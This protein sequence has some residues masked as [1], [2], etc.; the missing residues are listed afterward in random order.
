[1]TTPTVGLDV[2]DPVLPPGLAAPGADRLAALEA[3]LDSLT[4][5]MQHLDQQVA[6]LTGKAADD[7]RRQ[8]EWDDLAADFTPVAREMY[9][10][11]VAQLEEIQSY[12]QLEDVLHLV[13]RLAR[14]TRNLNEMLDLAESI[15]DL[16]RDLGPLTKEIFAQAVTT[17]DDLERKGY[18]GFLRQ[19]QY[20]LD[21]V[22][23]SFGEDDVRLL[24]DNIVVILN[25]V[26]ALTQPE[27]MRLAHVLTQGYQEVEAQAGEL[28]VSYMGLLGQMRDPEVRR[29]LALTLAL[30]KRISQ[31][32]PLTAPSSAARV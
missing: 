6:L 13:K 9:A 31:Q 8:R 11:T 7:R 5:L 30:L 15:Q 28:P 18:F 25:T 20:V 2:L 16:Q 3:K 22:I 23:T 26:K 14:N 12:V 24:G 1:M 21:Q 27:I 4:A 17:L 32:H 29:G 10:V 19:S